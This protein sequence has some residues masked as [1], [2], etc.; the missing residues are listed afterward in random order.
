[1]ASGGTHFEKSESGMDILLSGVSM[2]RGT[3]TV[4]CMSLFC[5]SSLI[6]SDNANKSDF[7][8]VYATDFLPA[9]G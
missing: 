7:D 5:P 2:V 3:I 9:D 8:K 4:E 6:R 1:M